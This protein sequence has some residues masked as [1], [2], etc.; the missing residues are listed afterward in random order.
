M[1]TVLTFRSIYSE[2]EDIKQQHL[3]AVELTENT[4]AKAAEAE[5]IAQLV[6]TFHVE[7]EL[8]GKTN[9]LLYN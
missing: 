7:A 6:V 1:T 4:T 8:I 2:Y 3:A 5:Q 9:Q